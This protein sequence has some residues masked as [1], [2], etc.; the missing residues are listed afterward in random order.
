MREAIQILGV[1]QSLYLC[2]DS[3]PDSM[4]RQEWLELAEKATRMEVCMIVSNNKDD[5][6]E[7][8]EKTLK[9]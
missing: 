9:H 8:D 2:I 6:D 1:S 5:D 7:I 4:G 3:L